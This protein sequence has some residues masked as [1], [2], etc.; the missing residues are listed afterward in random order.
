M[1][2][3]GVFFASSRRR[4]TLVLLGLAGLVVPGSVTLAP[5]AS[6]TS[7]PACG[8]AVPDG[9]SLV[10]T[11]AAIGAEQVFTV[12]HGVTRIRVRAVGGTGGG[13]WGAVDGVGQGAVVTA[14]VPVRPDTTLYVVVGGN[15]ASE[16]PATGNPGGFNGGGPGGSGSS[17]Q[18]GGGGGGASDIRTCSTASG[19][20]ESC[21]GDALGT[22]ADPRLVVAAGG[23]GLN[24]A[25]GGAGG[26]PD[27]APGGSGG[28]PYFCYIR[29]T[30]GGGATQSAPGAGGVPSQR[31]PN[32]QSKFSLGGG[33]GA[34][35]TAG[36]GGAG[37]GG[38]SD[39]STTYNGGGGGGGGY[40]GGGGGAG[41]FPGA[42]GGGGSSFATPSASNVE[43][44]LD[45]TATPS[46]TITYARPG[47]VVAGSTWYSDGTKTRT[48]STGAVIAAYAVGAL[49][50][51]PYRLVLGTGDPLHACTTV[52]QV[53]NETIVYAGPSGLI[54][55]VSGTL[56]P[57]L[58]PGTYKLCFE[59]SSSG[60]GTGTGGATFTVQ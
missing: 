4:V 48:G 60:N 59:D 37:G 46:V 8:P 16:G 50:N 44:G 45:T 3:R 43:F 2:A 26:T 49:Q 9:S 31:I 27:G 6:A 13:I 36:A 41:G 54:G 52:L 19:Q 35:G 33:P 30:G 58:D 39:A 57:G 1:P 7:A 38:G 56:Q 15:G 25:G 17:F 32:C 12:P 34:P 47:A 20:S 51:V 42:G 18:N 11:C 40:F 24:G 10:V 22:A 53:L 14:E 5:I 55:R 23:G 21:S 28:T 29:P